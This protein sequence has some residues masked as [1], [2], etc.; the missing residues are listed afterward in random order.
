MLSTTS[1]VCLS[2]QLHGGLAAAAQL[3]TY[4]CIMSLQVSTFSSYVDIMP[5]MV[6]LQAK[7]VQ[8]HIKQTGLQVDVVLVSPLTRALETAVGCFGNFS[9]PLNGTPPLM[10]ELT[11]QPG[12]RAAHPAVS[13][14]GCPPIVCYELCR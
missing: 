13:A 10:H 11:E 14:A 2:G 8:Q 9:S 6:R 1:L 7:A 3:H 4:S 12:K 5:A